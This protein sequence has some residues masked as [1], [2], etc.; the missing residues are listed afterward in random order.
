MLFVHATNRTAVRGLAAITVAC[1]VMATI[2]LVPAGPTLAQQ[3]Q[4]RAAGVLVDVVEM[5]EIR[6]TQAVIGRL[7]ATRQ[8]AV[9]S[10]IG[11]V[12]NEVSFNIGDTVEKGQTLAVLDQERAVLEQREAEAA[13]GVAKAE[14]EVADAKLKLAQ[15]AFERQ[16]SLLE[17]TAFSRSRYD[18]LKQQ[19]VQSRSERARALAQLQTAKSNLDQAAYEIEHSTI[20][21]PFSGIVVA[22]QAQPGQYVTQGGTIAILLDVSNLEVEADV[23]SRIANGLRVGQRVKATFETGVEKTVTLRSTIP[24]Q[25]VSTQT[26]PVRFSAKLKDLEAGHIAI[27]TVVTLA[28]P[29]S[30]PRNVV[31][32]PKDALLQQRGGWMV[33]VVKDDK[34]EA[35]RVELGQ[36]VGDRIEI[37]SGLEAGEVVVVR[38]NERLR[39]GQAVSPKRVSAGGPPQQG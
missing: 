35:R 29:V 3:Q 37:V 25:N 36:A 7:V 16:A 8:S 28:M 19:A 39:P 12:I 11:G 14:I 24:I 31:S 10:R 5:R 20:R 9:A 33:Y 2:I 34:A 17:S 27:G 6:D 18:D 4:Q 13:L 1:A 32:A 38:G 26:R 22:R 21:A 30:A 15:Q 23:P